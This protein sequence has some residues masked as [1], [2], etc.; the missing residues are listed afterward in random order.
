MCFKLTAV[1]T[2]SADLSVTC[3]SSRFFWCVCPAAAG[4]LGSRRDWWHLCGCQQQVQTDGFRLCQVRV[5]VSL[6]LSVCIFTIQCWEENSGVFVC[7]LVL[8]RLIVVHVVCVQCE[9]LSVCVCQGYLVYACQKLLMDGTICQLGRIFSSSLL[10]CLLLHR[11]LQFLCV[12]FVSYWNNMHTYTIWVLQVI[13]QKVEPKLNS[14]THKALPCGQK[15]FEHY[16][17]ILFKKSF[18]L[19]VLVTLM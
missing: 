6:T 1:K 15:P 12:Y 11:F 4:R 8:Q 2:C 7:I 3:N 14:L 17:N 9:N 5:C 18:Q 10:P 16:L 13:L 19:K